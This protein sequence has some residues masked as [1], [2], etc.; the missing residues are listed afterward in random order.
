MLLRRTLSPS[1]EVGPTRGRA[2]CCIQAGASAGGCCRA[3]R[4]V[5]PLRRE[6]GPPASEGRRARAL[7]GRTGLDKVI[8]EHST[9]EPDAAPRR[10]GVKAQPAG[11]QVSTGARMQS[12]QPDGAEESSTLPAGV[13]GS[14]ARLNERGGQEVVAR[15]GSGECDAEVRGQ[16]GQLC[17]RPWA[18]HRWA[19]QDRAKGSGLSGRFEPVRPAG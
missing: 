17:E 16:S 15:P 10:E 18:G 3:K 11:A 5:W 12:T 8:L 7:A 14:E 1:E 4:G 13:E 2:R 9:M 19:G 6:G